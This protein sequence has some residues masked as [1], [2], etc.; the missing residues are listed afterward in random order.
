MPA[1]FVI[2][3]SLGTGEVYTVD[4]T[5][6]NPVTGVVEHTQDELPAFIDEQLA[7]LDRRTAELE[8]RTFESNGMRDHIVSYYGI[9]L[10]AKIVDFIDIMTGKQTADMV[11]RRWI[12]GMEETNKLELGRANI[13]NATIEE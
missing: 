1:R 2:Q 10:W 13:G 5:Q 8:V 6:C 11:M 4:I 12:S 7:N 3:K 9:E